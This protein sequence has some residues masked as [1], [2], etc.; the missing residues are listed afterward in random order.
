[1]DMRD[2]AIKADLLEIAATRELVAA[3]S[4]EI[5]QGSGLKWHDVAGAAIVTAPRIPD[6]WFNRVM[7]LG[8]TRTASEADLDEIVAACRAATDKAYWIHRHP[9]AEPAVLDQWLVKRGFSLA[10]RRS[11]AKVARGRE[12]P[13]QFTTPMLIR[14]AEPRD[15]S[16]AA[17]VATSAFGMPPAMTSWMA[18]TFARPNWH[19]VVA[20]ERGNIVGTGAL[21]VSDRV[22]WLGV[23][24]VLQEF[25][26]RNAHRSLMALRIQ[27]ALDLGC[28]LIVTETGEPIGEEPNP[29]LA[30]M[31]RCGFRTVA[32]RLNYAAPLT[33]DAAHIRID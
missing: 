10:K 12:A 8:L 11:W 3:A 2:A 1:M 17:H 24:G 6:T 29:S 5:V 15:F 20:E 4:A 33:V 31:V 19:V 16:G 30:N 28:E 27:L 22:G 14:R 9:L 21:F 26:G 32:S 25:R 7:G 18:A 13:P 23:G